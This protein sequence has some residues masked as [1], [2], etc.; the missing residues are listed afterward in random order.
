MNAETVNENKF[1]IEDITSE[2]SSLAA[3]DKFII[4]DHDSTD[5]PKTAKITA[6]NIDKYVRNNLN[7]VSGDI[8]LTFAESGTTHGT[9]EAKVHNELYDNR[10][11]KSDVTD[12]NGDITRDG[13]VDEDLLLIRDSISTDKYGR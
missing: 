5:T 9:L 11:E 8:R 1:N 7:D 2:I 6:L 13:I 4:Y 12:A 3:E 10:V